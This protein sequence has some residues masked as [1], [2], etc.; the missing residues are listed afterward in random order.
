MC[1]PQ[2]GWK[3]FFSFENEQI[4]DSEVAAWWRERQAVAFADCVVSKQ[5]AL[6]A[7]V[8]LL[9]SSP[10]TPDVC[11]GVGSCDTFCGFTFY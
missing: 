5:V 7:N 6:R 4:V 3:L 2:E 1:L 11:R 8:A 10:R 9:S